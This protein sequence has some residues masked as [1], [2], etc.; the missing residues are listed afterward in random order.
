MARK[1]R[2][3]SQSP[4]LPAPF[5]HVHLNA[6]GIDVGAQSHYVAVPA[7]RDKKPVQE[8]GAFT[9]ELYR[10]ADWLKACRVDTVAMEST[11]VY[12]IAPHEILEAEGCRF[13]RSPG[14]SST[15]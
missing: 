8:F 12:W 10:L 3:A 15:K 13:I 11:G 4:L 6:A 7:D 9:Q 5:K 2:R 14:S 1:A